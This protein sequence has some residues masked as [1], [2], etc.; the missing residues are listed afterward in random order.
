VRILYRN[1]LLNRIEEGVVKTRNPFAF[2]ALLL[3]A[4]FECIITHG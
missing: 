4:T 2:L 3:Q 1:K